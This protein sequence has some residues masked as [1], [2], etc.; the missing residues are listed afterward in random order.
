MP[1]LE[2]DSMV[3]RGYHVNIRGAIKNR[4]PR[5]PGIPLKFLS[6]AREIIYKHS[7]HTWR[8]LLHHSHIVHE[9][10]IE[11]ELQNPII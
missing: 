1:L 9:D 11:T 3:T 7:R 4:L 2:A 5:S 6:H 10:N 8:Y